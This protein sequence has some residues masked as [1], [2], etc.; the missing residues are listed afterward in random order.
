MTTE[1]LPYRGNLTWLRDRTILCTTHGSRAYGLNTPTSDLDIKGIAVPPR[2]Y[3]H[4]FDKHFEQAESKDPDMVVYDIRKFFKLAAEC[5]PSVIEVLWV[6]ESEHRIITAA[7]RK[8]IDNRD[9]FLSKSAR[10]RFAGYAHSQLKRIKLHRRHLLNPPKAPPTRAEFG[11][12]ERTVIP[13][14]QLQAAHSAIEKKLGGWNLDDMSGVDPADRQRLQNMMAEAL[15]EYGVTKETQYQA[16]ARSIG[17]E[18]NFLRLL[19]LER[20]YK[21]RKTEWDQYQ[22]WKATRNPARAAIEAEFGLDLKHA[23]HLVRLI[24]MCREIL[25]TGRVVVKRPDREELLAIRNGAWSYE[26]IVEWAEREEAAMG[27]LYDKS[28]LPHH[29]DRA[30]LDALCIDLVEESFR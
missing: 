24:R 6:E 16:A 19:D 25:E 1:P 3:F 18:E 27:E 14:D 9:M 5:N 17:Y 2:E 21:A 29:P 11:L 4:G 13:A 12:P 10:W 28:S 7:G 23:V 26:Q 30:K 20:Q 22:N 15:A 8:L